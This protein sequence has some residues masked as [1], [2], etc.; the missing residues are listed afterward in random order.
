MMEETSHSTLKIA[1]LAYIKSLMYFQRFSSD[2]IDENDFKIAYGLLLGFKDV[3]GVLVVEDFIPYSH[4][5]QEYVIFEEKALLITKIKNLNLKYNDDEFPSYIL[6]WARNAIDDSRE[7]TLIDKKNH[8]FFQAIRKNSFF[9][10]FNYT[11]LA[12]DYGIKIYEFEEDYKAINLT[13]NL[14][15]KSFSFSKSVYIED[16]INF[17]IEMEDKR[18][19]N[20]ILIEGIE[21]KEEKA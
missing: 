17:A 19:N 10:I 9:W 14:R 3:D 11:D 8:N 4:F 18:K 1:P 6:G 5:N 13:S 2:Y 15:E 20:E 12:I 16:I 21:E 7:P